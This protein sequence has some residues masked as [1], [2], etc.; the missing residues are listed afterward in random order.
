MHFYLYFVSSEM[1]KEMGCI[2]A[3]DTIHT[4]WEKN[5]VIVVKCERALIEINKCWDNILFQ[6]FISIYTQ[7][8]AK[9]I[10]FASLEAFLELRGIKII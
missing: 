8:S 3:N 6:T 9:V 10:L 5:N 1:K 7:Q 4:W 2:V